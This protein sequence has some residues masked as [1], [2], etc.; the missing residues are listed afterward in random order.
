MHQQARGIDYDVSLLSFDLLAC[1]ISVRIDAGAAFLR[2]FH[3]LAV[4]LLVPA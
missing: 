3:A 4:D 2:A 1:V